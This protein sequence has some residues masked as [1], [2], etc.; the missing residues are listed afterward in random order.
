MLRKLGRGGMLVQCM[1]LCLSASSHQPRPSQEATG[2]MHVQRADD[3]NK[4]SSRTGCLGV[5]GWRVVGNATEPQ[6]FLL[7][8]G[9]TATTRGREATRTPEATRKNKSLSRLTSPRP[10]RRPSDPKPLFGPFP[11][12]LHSTLTLTPT[13]HAPPPPNAGASPPPPVLPHSP[14][15]S[16]IA[17]RL[18]PS[19][20]L[21]EPRSNRRRRSASLL[22]YC[23]AYDE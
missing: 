22:I 9:T 21:P 15:T 7:S 11:T 17:L 18:L 1:L 16:P 2:A 12:P 8:R 13:P 19:I 3:L 4:K 6:G 5:G 23:I 20:L 14:A 10:S